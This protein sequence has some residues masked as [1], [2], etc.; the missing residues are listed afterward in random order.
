M[1]KIGL[2]LINSRIGQSIL[3]ALACLLTAYV[4]Y[5]WAYNNGKHDCEASVA[6]QQADANI[7]V[8]DEGVK[9]D[10]TSSD[11][12]KD[13]TEKATETVAKI[14]TTTGK[15]TE[16]IRYV[17]RDRPRTTPVAPGSCVHPVDDRVQEVFDQAVHRANGSGGPL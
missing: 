4:A 12:S 5:R 13:T 10:A 6:A 16:V 1:M 8:H 17:Y 9:R 2:W 14:D 7:Q 15:Q 11:I 3:L